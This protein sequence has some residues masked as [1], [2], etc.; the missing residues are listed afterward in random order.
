VNGGDAF[1]LGIEDRQSGLLADCV[2]SQRGLD[3]L[4][5]G[6]V[7]LTYALYPQC[8]GRGLASRAVQLATEMGRRRG[9][10][11]EFVI[12]VATDNPES[13]RVATE[14]ASDWYG[15]PKLIT[16]TCDDMWCRPRPSTHAPDRCDSQPRAD[17]TVTRGRV[18]R[19]SAKSKTAC[20]TQMMGCVARPLSRSNRD[21]WRQPN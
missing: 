6:Q 2:G 3:Y 13:S 15:R 20:I 16:A 19:Y 4:S 5:V 9:P 11:S 7:N 18:L 10:V 8:R 12:R 21:H 14:L 17:A 1:D